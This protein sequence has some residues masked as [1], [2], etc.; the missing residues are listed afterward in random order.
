MTAHVRPDLAEAER[1]KLAGRDLGTDRP[2]GRDGDPYPP[3]HRTLQALELLDLERHAWK[4]PV[5]EQPL[6]RQRGDRALAIVENE[7]LVLEV[8]RGHA[9]SC[10]PRMVA[11]HDRHQLVTPDV[12]HAYALGLDRHRHEPHVDVRGREPREG[13][14][15]MGVGD[16]YFDA[17]E[18]GAK[19]RQ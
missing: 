14:L 7:R 4:H 3:T 9:G 8:A 19:R 13:R 15:G 5:C 12:E 1:C 10:G 6:E 2:G 11:W 18:A 16:P 17:R